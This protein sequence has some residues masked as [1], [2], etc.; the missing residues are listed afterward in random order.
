LSGAAHGKEGKDADVAWTEVAF[1]VTT[2]MFMGRGDTAADS[3]RIPELRGAL[4]FWFRALAAPLVGNDI[5]LLAALEANLFGSAAGR[6][7]PS[8]VRLRLDGDVTPVRAGRTADPLAPSW[9]QPPHA[10]APDRPL[11]NG[12]GYLLGPGL[13]QPT[14]RGEL[15]RVG[16]PYLQ[17]GQPGVLGVDA[18]GRGELVACCLWALATFGG[19]G[20]RARRGFGGVAFDPADL[21]RLAPRFAHAIE[22][23]R[24][25]GR[26]AVFQRASLTNVQAVFTATA[27]EEFEQKLKARTPPTTD[28]ERAR[29]PQL[30]AGARRIR[31]GRRRWPS[32]HAAL[33]DVGSSMRA[34]RAVAYRPQRRRFEEWVTSEYQQIVVPWLD[35]RLGPASPDGPP[36]FP[37]GAFGLPIVFKDHATAEVEGLRRASPLWIR[38]V[39]AGPSEWTVLY[40]LFRTQFLPDGRQPRL[41][42][43][44]ASLPLFLDDDLVDER[45]DAWIDKAP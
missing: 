35:G 38:P 31:M 14:R 10:P 17:P 25:Q 11:V 16:R 7:T 1:E 19:L 29:Y 4:R 42:K 37:V 41:V 26:W 33:H 27:L 21:G 43:D 34:D 20:A 45:L 9:L 18:A 28:V 12:L 8:P 44:R 22:P 13:F 24:R 39:P 30:V 40:H 32:W 6:G 23:A 15:D 5:T 3:I 2:P 36:R